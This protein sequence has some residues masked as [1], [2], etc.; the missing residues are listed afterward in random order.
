MS[1]PAQLVPAFEPRLPSDP[2]RYGIGIVGTGWIV[3]DAH[4]PA[5]DKAGFRVEAVYDLDADTAREVAGARGIPHVCES[6]DELLG[7][8][9]VDIVDIAVPAKEQPEIALAAIATG[10]DL[11]CQKPFA[12]TYG[13]ARGIVDAAEAAGRTVAVNQNMRYGAAWKVLRGLVDSG[14]IGTPRSAEIQVAV[15]THWHEYGEWLVPLER[16]EI[17]YHSIHYF[18]ALRVLLGDPT[19]VYCR[20]L[21]HPE[22]KVV[23]ETWTTALLEYPDDRLGLVRID[24]NDLDDERDWSSTFRLDGLGGVA[25]GTTWYLFEGAIEKGERLTFRCPEATG[26]AWI[27]PHLANT[28]MPDSFI[29]TMGELQAALEA[30]EQPSHSGR[31]NLK[32]LQLVFAAYRSMAEHRPVALDEI[33]A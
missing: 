9:D 14:W 10:K 22:Q 1:A 4:L 25:K 15:T 6:L 17:M 32:T 12:E 29:G 3:Q 30:G 31:D 11:L 23:G 24:H 28:G 13:E 20:G 5:Y 27:E 33:D 19:S 8:D 7:R 18:D 16:L 2:K 26:E 21:R